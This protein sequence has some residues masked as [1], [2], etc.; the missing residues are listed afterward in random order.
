MQHKKE[1]LRRIRVQKQGGEEVKRKG[2]TVLCFG[3]Y[4]GSQEEA[5]VHAAC[6]VIWTVRVFFNVSFL[7]IL[8]C[9]MA[10]FCFK[11]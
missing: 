2:I 6:A 4:D 11:V 9:E 8:A 7:Y 3:Y 5:K 10:R 1:M